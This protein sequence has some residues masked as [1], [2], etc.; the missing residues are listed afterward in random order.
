MSGLGCLGI[1]RHVDSRLD[2]QRSQVR[3]KKVK[4]LIR[5]PSGFGIRLVRRN[6]W[7]QPRIIVSVC[8]GV[9]GGRLFLFFEFGIAPIRAFCFVCLC[10]RTFS[11]WIPFV[12]GAGEMA[13]LR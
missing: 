13:R 10:M 11:I 9:H 5:S 2:W 12:S 7:I 6:F 3:K 4:Q 1:D 8:R